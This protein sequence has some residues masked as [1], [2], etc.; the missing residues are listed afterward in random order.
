MATAATTTLAAPGRAGRRNLIVALVLGAI[1]T[2]LIVAFLASRDSTTNSAAAGAT[3]QVVVATRDIP[4]G[5]KIDGN[6]VALKSIPQSAV[7][8]DPFSKTEEVV[9]T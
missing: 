3:L 5:T 2:G 1:A 4:I 6:M 8:S 9:G 7:I